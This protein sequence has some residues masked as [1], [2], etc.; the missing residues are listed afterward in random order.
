MFETIRLEFDGA[1]AAVTLNRPDRANAMTEHMGRELLTG[2][3]EIEGSPRTRCVV[4]TGAGQH[5]CAG[6]D[7]AEFQRLQASRS[8]AETEASVR[9]F[10]DVAAAIRS[11]PQPV[12]AGLNGDAFGGGAGL[13]LACDLRIAAETARFGLTF[14]RMGLSGADAGVTYFLPRLVGLAKA[15]ELL[16]LGQV[17]DAGEALR[18]GLVQR[19]VAPGD[20]PEAV[21]ETAARL[22]AGPPI[23]LRLTKQALHGSLERDFASQLAFESGAQTVCLLSED[24]AEGVRAFLDR[25]PPQF[26][27]R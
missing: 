24:H 25:R 6:G 7:F 18:L 23:G 11:L 10:L 15:S 27:G 19:V 22:A 12:V 13:A 14:V 21:A 3:G 5:F 26:V 4:L 2:L 20:L 1:V 17:V 16:L 9:V 8:A